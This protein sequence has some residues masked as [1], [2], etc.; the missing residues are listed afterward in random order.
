MHMYKHT[1][2]QVHPYTYKYTYMYIYMHV[3]TYTHLY[4]HIYFT[5]CGPLKHQRVMSGRRN[6]VFRTIMLYVE[7]NH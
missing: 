3:C 5:A 6:Q 1:F 4:I 7:D 2:T